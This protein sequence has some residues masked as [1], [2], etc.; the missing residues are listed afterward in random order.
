M[1]G[2][3]PRSLYIHLGEIA[4]VLECSREDLLQRVHSKHSKWSKRKIPV[5]QNHDF[6]NLALII[7]EAIQEI[8]GIIQLIQNECFQAL[9]GLS[10]E[11]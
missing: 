4:D 11:V 6:N 7:D 10:D 5:S 9:G 2:I 1:Y 8:D 3:N